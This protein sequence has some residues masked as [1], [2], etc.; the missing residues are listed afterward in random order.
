MIASIEKTNPTERV[1]KR[2]VESALSGLSLAS[3]RVYGSRIRQWLAWARGS[4]LNRENVKS[5]LRTLE[6]EG[7]S[8]QVRNQT[9][10]ALKRLASESCES[11]WIDHESAGR[12][13]TIKS[14]KISG[15]RTGRWLSVSQAIGLM[16][17]PDRTCVAGRR[18]AAALALLLGCGLRRAEACALT[19]DQIE[20]KENDSGS[21]RMFLVNL[22][23][24]GGRTRT[25]Q[26]PGWAADRI[27]EWRK[28]LTD[29]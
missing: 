11:G 15:V 27:L 5:Y 7:A 12:I 6:T 2:I 20:L 22:V 13:T 8:A 16:Q 4:P 1:T 25:I 9:L 26:V 14:K 18:D 23:G 3:R 24:K 29:A 21:D 28:D 10:A 17:A 19:L